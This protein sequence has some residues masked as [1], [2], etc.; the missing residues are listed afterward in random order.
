M[1]LGLELAFELGS[2]LV[3]AMEFRSRLESLSVFPSELGL[4]L[5]FELG[6]E[7]QSVLEFP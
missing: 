2:E 7:F 3:S 5:A 1:Q 6:S 4:E